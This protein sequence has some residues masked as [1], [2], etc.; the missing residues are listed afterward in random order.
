[1]LRRSLL[2]DYGEILLLPLTVR[3]RSWLGHLVDLERLALLVISIRG[4]RITR[5]IGLLQSKLISLTRTI[6]IS[7]IMFRSLTLLRL[8]CSHDLRI[9]EPLLTHRLDHM[10]RGPRDSSLLWAWPWL[11]LLRSSE[12]VVWSFFWRYALCRILFLHIFALMSITCII[13]FRDTILS[14]VRHSIMRY[15]TWSIRGWSTWLGPMWPPILYLRILHMQSLLL[16]VFSRLIWM[17]MVLL[18]YG[19]S[20]S[21]RLRTWFSWHGY[22]TE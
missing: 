9:R 15:R 18:A 4:L 21:S 10:H 2:E 14:V 1:M 7:R 20:R 17:L 12:M 11:E 13:K 5:F 8:A 3:G 19:I 6:S 22:I 16:L